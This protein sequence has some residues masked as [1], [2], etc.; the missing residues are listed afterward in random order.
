MTLV[1]RVLGAHLLLFVALGS[2]IAEPSSKISGSLFFQ[3]RGVLAPTGSAQ[4]LFLTSTQSP[5]LMPTDANL[6]FFAPL[7]ARP[8]PIAQPLP[9]NLPI[10]LPTQN[11]VMTAAMRAPYRRPKGVTSVDQIRF[12]IGQA[13][14]RR[15]GYDAVQH[16]AKVR[17][18][19]KPTHMTIR[20]IYAW[21]DATPGQPHAIGRYQ[22]IPKTLKRVVNELGVSHG[23][24]FSPDVQDALSD[25]LLA[26][27]GLYEFQTGTLP[28]HDF[29]N[30]LAKIWAGLPT[31]NGK[32][33]YHGFAGNKAS[34][35]WK[36]F[37]AQM[38]KI[39]SG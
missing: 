6:G 22:F 14:S 2:A 5:S 4:P 21:F 27:A 12:I 17:P 25:I 8:A 26:D 33:H 18:P 35:T 7:P 11:H 36:A 30:N 31:S 15:D 20:E 39:Q 1:Y 32:S 16:G 38:Q 19:K 37:D 28:R 10:A 9:A 23:A 13:E 24:L 29:M 34:I 3:S